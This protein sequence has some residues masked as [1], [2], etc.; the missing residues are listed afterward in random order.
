MI[1]PRLLASAAVVICIAAPAAAQVIHV[2]SYPL[3]GTVPD[4]AFGSSVSGAGDVNNDGYDD[5]IIGTPGDNTVAYNAGAAFVYSGYDGAVLHALYGQSDFDWFGNSVSAAGDVNNDGFDDLV[6]G[7]PQ[8]S[9]FPAQAGLIRVFSG[10][11]GAVI[12]TVHGV[13]N[14][15]YFGWSV[16]GAGDVNNDGFDDVIAG[17]YEALDGNGQSVGAARV[18]SG[19]DGALLYQF[20]G[21]AAT[22]LFG[23]TVDGAGDVNNDGF[24]DL[25]VGASNSDIDGPDA[26]L[27]R[28]FSGA[29]GT[30]LHEW[31]GGNF[32]DQLGFSV[33]AAGD[34]NN[35]GYAD[36]IIGAPFDDNNGFESGSARVFSG[37]TGAILYTFSGETT[38]IFFGR[39]VAGAG[40]V[41]ADGFDD[42]L[43]AAP[44]DEIN[45]LISGSAYIFSGAT[46]AILMTYHGNNPGDFFGASV[47]GAGD[48]NGD[49]LA[50]FIISSLL[51]DR[52]GPN[53]GSARV[54]YSVLTAPPT[55]C[56]GDLTADNTVDV[57]DL[58]QVLSNWLSACP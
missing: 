49:G 6:V 22:D 50:D 21:D 25:I 42:L 30:V 35:D 57:D 19:V 5:F 44:F 48:V 12:Y 53:A 27:A 2:P 51:D 16:A 3:I 20:Y 47:G 14:D 15:E 55:P 56:P 8:I 1:P 46:G 39:A 32:G 17:A 24:D 9:T 58:N 11:N 13:S 43:V 52:G 28:V 18:Y 38:N 7:A 23:R 10:L 26:G 34:V 29:N 45:G 37:L 41:N 4:G 36:L 33:A 31:T 54:F 40:D